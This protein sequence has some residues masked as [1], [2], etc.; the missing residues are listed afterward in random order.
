MQRCGV[1]WGWSLV[2]HLLNFSFSCFSPFELT[3]P[4]GREL[5]LQKPTKTATRKMSLSR[6]PPSE[7]NKSSWDDAMLM[8]TVRCNFESSLSKILFSSRYNYR[9]YDGACRNLEDV[10]FPHQWLRLKSAPFMDAP[11]LR[12]CTFRRG[13][14]L[15]ELDRLQ[16]ASHWELSMFLPQSARWA[17]VSFGIA[18][19][20]GLELYQMRSS[21]F[22]S[23]S[24]SCSFLFFLF[25]ISSPLIWNFLGYD[26]WCYFN[27]IFLGD[28]R[29]CYINWIF[30]GSDRW[31]V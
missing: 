8:M 26:C 28:D 19:G 4:L 2:L 7:Q 18:R 16:V 20:W 31:Y 17:M 13:F 6:D 29:W 10:P 3:L 15:L 12:R 30:H 22:W 9:F 24:F 14:Y 1:P 11:V 21:C 27:W 5:L 25:L 23:F